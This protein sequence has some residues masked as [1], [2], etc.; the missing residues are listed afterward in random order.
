M[1][2]KIDLPSWLILWIWQALLGEVYPNIRAIAV[3]FSESKCLQIRYYL[4]RDPIDFDRE[5]LACVVTTI[6]SNASSNDEI[7]SVKEECE[8]STLPLP[9]L[10]SL[11]GLVYARRE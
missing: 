9:Q 6:P 1:K 10:D 5:S 3:S 7:R 4:D 8:H 11:D 2:T